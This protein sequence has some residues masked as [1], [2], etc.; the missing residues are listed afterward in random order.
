[1]KKRTEITVE[2]DEIIIIRQPRRLARIWCRKCARQVMMVTVDQ[3][4]A[5]TGKSSRLIFRMAEAGNI[6]FAETSEGFLLICLQSLIA[7]SRYEA[8]DTGQDNA[9][10]YGEQ[11]N[12]KLKKI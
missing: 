2:T 7:I 3:A 6:H 1:M 12:N 10:D 4:A 5:V 8:N 9:E 11:L